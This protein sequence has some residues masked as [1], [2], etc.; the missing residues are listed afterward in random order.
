MCNLSLCMLSKYPWDTG[1]LS[2]LF[3]LYL[4]V[5]FSITLLLSLKVPTSY[6]SILH[7]GSG[8]N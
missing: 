6:G 4:L 3:E 2:F 8:Q 1:F 5:N 7:L